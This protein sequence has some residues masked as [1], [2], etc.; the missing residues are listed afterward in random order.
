MPLL[1]IAI[2]HGLWQV[3]QGALMAALPDLRV[4]LC[5]RLSVGAEF[6]HLT[7]S[8]V[9][10]LPDQSQVNA[11]L[12]VLG[13]AERGREVLEE[14]AERLQAMLSTTCDSPASVRITVMD[15]KG[16]FARR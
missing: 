9:F 3:R 14:V 1:S 6:A 7:V 11:D 10:G 8:P 15:P 5:E 12:R 4:M 13:K 16:Y 2:D